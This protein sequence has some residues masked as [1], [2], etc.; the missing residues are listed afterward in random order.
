MINFDVDTLC[1]ANK[2][3]KLKT[4]TKTSTSLDVFNLQSFFSNA[5]STVTHRH[6]ELSKDV[7]EKLNSR[8][9][10]ETET[11]AL[12]IKMRPRQ[13][14]AVSYTHLTLPTNREV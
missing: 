10:D 1:D 6:L 8:G 13:D 3:M 5:Y 11:L 2:T 7:Y 4:K 12:P 9:R 14:A